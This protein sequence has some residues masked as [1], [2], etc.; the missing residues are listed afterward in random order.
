MKSTEIDLLLQLL[1]NLP[2]IGPRS[3]RRIIL[4]LIKNNNNLMKPLSQILNNVSNNIKICE[5]CGNYCVNIMCDIC[6][7]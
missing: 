2:G 3:A 1:S 6:K 4:H 7:K 5:S